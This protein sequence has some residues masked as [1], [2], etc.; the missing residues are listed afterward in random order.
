MRDYARLLAKN[1]TSFVT[2]KSLIHDH[3]GWKTSQLVALHLKSSCTQH[4]RT[5]AVITPVPARQ[6]LAAHRLD[7]KAKQ[8]SRQGACDCP[9]CKPCRT[10]PWS[11][12]AAIDPGR[13]T[14]T[15]VLPSWTRATSGSRRSHPRPHLPIRFPHALGAPVKQHRF[16]A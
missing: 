2:Y 4:F 13:K 14:L 15:Q 12:P 8:S 3:E 16:M 9:A 1:Q 10:T 5:P 6:L 11:C 7:R